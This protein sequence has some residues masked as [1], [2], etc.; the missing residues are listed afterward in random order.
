MKTTRFLTIAAVSCLTAAACSEKPSLDLPQEDVR[1]RPAT[2]TFIQTRAALDGKT[3]QWQPKDFLGVYS[4]AEGETAAKTG[5]AFANTATSVSSSA[6]FEGSIVEGAVKAY[7]IHP[8]YHA[9]GAASKDLE[10][11]HQFDPEK[12]AFT[13][14]LPSAQQ[15]TE[16]TFAPNANVAVCEAVIGE[17]GNLSGEMQNACAYLKFTLAHSTDRPVR[18]VMVTAVNEKRFSGPATVTF[19]K[20]GTPV[21]AGRDA[22]YVCGYNVDQDTAIA[23]GTYYL[24]VFPA[25]LTTAGQ[26]GLQV[27]L[28]GLDGR[29]YEFT[30]PGFKM[31]RNQVYNLGVLDEKAE[32]VAG[33]LCIFATSK[34]AA[35]TATA[36]STER[37]TW[38]E[39]GY[40]FSYVKDYVNNGS[41]RLQGKGFIACPAVTGKV[42]KEVSLVARGHNANNQAKFYVVKDSGTANVGA[43][44]D[45]ATG[46]YV[47]DGEQPGTYDMGRFYNACN[48]IAF[49]C[50]VFRLGQLTGIESARKDGYATPAAGTGYQLYNIANNCLGTT[51]EFVYENAE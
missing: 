16:G 3:I 17:D 5:L 20:N 14:V 21:I 1:L 34:G 11:A 49:Y 43:S 23:D 44:A 28:S 42:L 45:I 30:T 36:T 25:D 8:M 24:C 33:K 27:R 6:I 39:D 40:T 31:V 37:K 13:T 18:Q 15:L 38:T 48:G 19:D 35:E 26:E 2:F 47:A 10:T 22:H 51:V 7:A 46:I 41:F 9:A 32:E 29:C 50:H 12:V 4:F